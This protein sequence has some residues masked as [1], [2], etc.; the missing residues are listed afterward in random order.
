MLRVTGF[1]NRVLAAIVLAALLTCT[2]ATASE[3]PEPKA[4][5]IL[6]ITVH[7]PVMHERYRQAIEPVI[8]NH[9]GR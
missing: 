8:L 2:N 5:V 3:S 7:D 6:D 9:G 4:C 1:P